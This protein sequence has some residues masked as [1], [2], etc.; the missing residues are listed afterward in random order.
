MKLFA[1]L[2]WLAFTVQ[3]YAADSLSVRSPDGNIE[4]MVY[5][6]QEL[7]YSISYEAKRFFQPSSIDLELRTEPGWVRTY[8]SKGNQLT[9]LTRSSFLRCPRKEK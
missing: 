7:R 3:L 5:Y 9:P 6:K 8:A 4:V 2:I 1:V